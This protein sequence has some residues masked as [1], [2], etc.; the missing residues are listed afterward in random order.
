MSHH[1]S[2]PN[3][4][5]PR[6]DAR[7]DLADL[8]AF[9]KPNDP[10]RSILILDAHPSSSLQPAGVTT[11]EP[12]APNARYEIAIDTN[13]DA[14]AEIVYRA[15][16]APGNGGQIATLRRIEG[17]NEQVIVERV[18]VSTGRDVRVAEGRG[19]RFCA[20]WRSD[21]FFFDVLGALHDLTFTGTDYFADKDICSIAI[22]VPN[23]ALGAARVALWMRALVADGNAWIQ[24]ERGARPQISVFLAGEARDAYQAASPADDARFV[25]A[26]AHA[27]E[28]A[29]GYTPDAATRAAEKLLPDILRYDPSRPASYPSN[30]RAPADD[31]VAFFLPILTNGKIADDGVR[32][33]RDLLDELP[34]LGPP[35]RVR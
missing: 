14:A 3:F 32:A 29:G 35:H 23:A 5:F 11:A 31:V 1:Y 21:P 22:E 30:G 34:Y 19:H 2:G 33:H 13:G 17:T 28:H 26:F 8:Y 4:G 15:T 20:G 25:P 16:F 24:V 10:G 7:L 6:G 9:P 27:L 12:F 18:P